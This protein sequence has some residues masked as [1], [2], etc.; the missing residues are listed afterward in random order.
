METGPKRK[1]GEAT[2]NQVTIGDAVRELAAHNARA[3]L[4]DE[5][6]LLL[7]LQSWW[8][9]TYNRPLKDPILL[10][11]TLEE[12]LYEFYDRIERQK[13]YEE[14][15]DQ[16]NDTIEKEKEQAA[17]DWAD[18]EERKELELLKNK[19]DKEDSGD[20]QEE[21]DPTRDPDNIKW[22]EEQIEKSKQ[23]YGESFGEDISMDFEE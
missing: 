19:Q 5:Y 12:L 20:E 21:Y 23:I 6:Q 7:F 17:N 8:S 15:I 16:E 3:G 11:Y 14:Q 2:G 22:M 18:E 13:A 10:S 1:G 4:D 9:R